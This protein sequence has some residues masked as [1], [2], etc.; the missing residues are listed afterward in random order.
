[1]SIAG[2][3][4]SVWHVQQVEMGKNG[5][6]NMSADS[7]PAFREA[8][9]KRIFSIGIASS[10]SDSFKSHLRGGFFCAVFADFKGMVA[11]KGFGSC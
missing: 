1:M 7:F 8:C 6:L 4:M 2:C 9:F 10:I 11:D 3:N 5:C